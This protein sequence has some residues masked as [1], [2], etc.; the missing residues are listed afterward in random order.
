MYMVE[1]VIMFLGYYVYGQQRIRKNIESQ[2]E[3]ISTPKA[4]R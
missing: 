1:I 2:I 4:M 3:Q